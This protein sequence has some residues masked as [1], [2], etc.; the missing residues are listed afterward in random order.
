MNSEFLLS[1][2][3]YLSLLRQTGQHIRERFMAGRPA[4]VVLEPGD[5]TRYQ[6]TFAR[7][8]HTGDITVAS[9]TG[10]ECVFL[11]RLECGPWDFPGKMNPVTKSLLCDICREAGGAPCQAFY[12]KTMGFSEGF[13]HDLNP[14][15][16][17]SEP[18]WGPPQF[19]N[20]KVDPR[21]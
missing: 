3:P 1:Y 8:D 21:E 15:S 10:E 14:P 13:D 6:F 16:P 18:V 5:M 4:F 19:M 17:D 20:R 7:N 2:I 12:P 11:G 9:R